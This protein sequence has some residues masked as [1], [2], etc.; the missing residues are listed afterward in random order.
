MITVVWAANNL[1]PTWRRSIGIAL[2]VAVGNAGG[3]LGYSIFVESQK[4]RYW[5]GYSVSL[6]A[7]IVGMCLTVLLK[8]SLS[9][10]NKR[11]DAVEA[12]QVKTMYTEAQLLALGDKSPL[13]RS[14]L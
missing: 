3:G 12:E 2:V 7:C 4:P 6:G 5:S 10:E 8:L 1:A 14:A 9:K 13:Y 11:R